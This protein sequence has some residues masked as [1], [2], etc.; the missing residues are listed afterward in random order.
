M[1]FLVLSVWTFLRALF[2]GAAAAGDLVLGALLA[3]A[4]LGASLLEPYLG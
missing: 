1:I 2:G 4:G 3:A